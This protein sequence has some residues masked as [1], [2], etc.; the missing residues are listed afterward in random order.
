MGKPFLTVE[1]QI[2]L[3]ESRGVSR[4]KGERCAVP[5]QQGH[6]GR[7]RRPGAVEAR[8]AVPHRCR[9]Q[10]GDCLLCRHT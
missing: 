10:R 1:E 3:L 4:T 8:R 6:R 7:V 5:R 2:E 9:Q